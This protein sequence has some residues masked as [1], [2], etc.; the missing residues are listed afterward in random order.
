MTN[1]KWILNT[2]EVN[3]YK[4]RT[5]ST[6]NPSE[7]FNSVLKRI[8]TKEVKAQVCI[9]SIYELYQYYNIIIQ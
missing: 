7:S 8:F 2:P 4:E 3:I 1:G 6:N 5:G 9:L